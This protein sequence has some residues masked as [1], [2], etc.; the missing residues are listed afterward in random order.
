VEATSK[1]KMHIGAG[2]LRLRLAGACAVEQG[3][4]KAA[5]VWRGWQ[6]GRAVKTCGNLE[7]WVSGEDDHAIGPSPESYT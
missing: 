6:W 4:E 3:R 7:L 1:K 2:I 5:P